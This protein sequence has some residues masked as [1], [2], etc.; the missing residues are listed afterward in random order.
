VRRFSRAWVVL[1]V[2]ASVYMV[3]AWLATTLG[4]SNGSVKPHA[5]RSVTALPRE[6]DS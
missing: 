5:H 1:L 6:L 4:I 3:D 2:V